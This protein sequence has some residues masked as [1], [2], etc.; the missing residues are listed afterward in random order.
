M[1][2]RRRA[3]DTRWRPFAN[4]FR[5]QGRWREQGQSL[6]RF[7]R[8]GVHRIF[9]IPRRKT[10]NDP[11]EDPQANPASRVWGQ[12]RL[13][14][15][16]YACDTARSRERMPS[17]VRNRCNGAPPQ[18]A[19]F[20]LPSRPPG[21]E[22][23]TSPLAGARSIQLSYR[24]ALRDTAQRARGPFQS[25][26]ETPFAQTGGVDQLRTGGIHESATRANPRPERRG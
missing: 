12:R 26:D 9:R 2:K 10:T 24:P 17:L 6:N 19:N 11:Q 14:L 18:I 8:I 5:R 3:A 21:L 22:P 13:V 4:S 7:G 1:Q 23:G 20:L 25:R 16:G 15:R